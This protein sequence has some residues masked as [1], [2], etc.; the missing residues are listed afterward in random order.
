MPPYAFIPP[1]KQ[2]SPSRD[3]YTSIVST[4]VLKNLN[5]LVSIHVPGPSV[6][7]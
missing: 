4:L 5:I 6:N 3:V 1:N 7:A 2:I